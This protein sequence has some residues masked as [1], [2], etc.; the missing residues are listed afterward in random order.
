MY[1]LIVQN[2][3]EP[4]DTFVACKPL[5]TQCAPDLQC[6]AAWLWQVCNS[7]SAVLLERWLKCRRL[8]HIDQAGKGVVVGH[9]VCAG[10]DG[11]TGRR[12][13]LSACEEENL[14]HVTDL[15]RQPAG[16]PD[17][18]MA[19]ALKKDNDGVAKK[20]MEAGAGSLPMDRAFLLQLLRDGRLNIAWL[21]AKTGAVAASG[22]EYSAP[23]VRMAE[24]NIHSLHAMV[25]FLE[26]REARDTSKTG[27]LR[28]K[29]PV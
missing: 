19:F 23:P 22:E 8:K 15:L 26:A 14:Q 4:H 5:Y 21:L 28:T 11:V 16:D 17:D 18:F 13:L 1:S 9:M 24:T 25:D 27:H 3:P 6:F 7:D 20:L 2:I 10:L 12:C 29:N